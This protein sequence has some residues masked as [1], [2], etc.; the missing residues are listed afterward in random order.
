MLRQYQSVQVSH[1]K[2]RIGDG[3]SFYLLASSSSEG[4]TSL[5]ISY[6]CYDNPNSLSDKISASMTFGSD[7]KYNMLYSVY[8]YPNILLPIFGGLL[9]DKMGLG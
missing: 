8:S 5:T 9:V 4:N 3:S 2:I 6:F 1:L 7:S